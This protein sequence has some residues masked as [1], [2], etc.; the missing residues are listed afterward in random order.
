MRL[1]A[2]NTSGVLSTTTRIET[3]TIQKTTIA[4]KRLQESFPLQQGL[5]LRGVPPAFLRSWLQESFPLQQGLKRLSCGIAMIPSF[6]SGVLS[7][8]TRIETPHRA[9]FAAFS[10]S[11][12]V[13]S[14]TTRIET[15]KF[16]REHDFPNTLQESFPLQQGL[17]RLLHCRVDK[18]L[19][20][21][22]SPFHYNKD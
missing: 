8:T 4:M 22:R 3:S 14:T 9:V 16:W 13:L 21:F 12:G 7:T 10:A 2:E 19:P 20:L 6:A 18:H 11:S 17:K 15:Q 5:K 1:F